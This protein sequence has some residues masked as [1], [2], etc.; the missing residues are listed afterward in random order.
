[1]V[2]A[3]GSG[4]TKTWNSLLAGH[5]GIQRRDGDLGAWVPDDGVPMAERVEQWLKLAVVEAIADANLG[6][7]MR[8]QL[9]VVVGSSRG[10]QAALESGAPLPRALPSRL[11]EGVARLVGSQGRVATVMAACA[12]A[13]WAIAEAAAMVRYGEVPV[14]I[15]AVSDG[16]ITPLSRAGFG[17]LGVLARTGCFPF[18]QQREGLVLGEGAAAMVLMA[19]DRVPSGVPV[20]GVVLGWG[21]TNDASHPTHLPADG[22]A[23]RR[24]VQQCLD[25][26]GL[27]LRQIDHLHTHGTGTQQNDRHEAALISALFGD[28]PPHL[29]ATKGATGHALSATGMMEAIFCLLTLRHQILPPCI[30]LKEPEFDLPWVLPERTRPSGLIAHSLNLCFGFGGQNTAVAFGL[31][32]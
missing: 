21:M 1:M 18:S 27:T 19:G 14:A 11:S 24:G 5:T 3:L 6:G 29:S 31:P 20:Y 16:A 2:S 23:A 26:S 7:S 30:G 8:S 4:V 22:I 9:G 12:T 25:R 32:D 28:R 13:N 17:Q 10:Y 15:A